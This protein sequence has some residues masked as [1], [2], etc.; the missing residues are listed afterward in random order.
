MQIAC[1]VNATK[2]K[3]LAVKVTLHAHRCVRIAHNL[4]LLKKPEVR[5]SRETVPF[6][7]IQTIDRLC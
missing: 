3:L 2:C 4:L 6:K 7:T 5:K 1:G